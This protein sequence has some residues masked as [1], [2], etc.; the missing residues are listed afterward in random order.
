MKGISCHEE[1][2]VNGMAVTDKEIRENFELARELGCNFMR[3]AH[4]SHPDKPVIIT[5]TGGGAKAGQHGSKS[6]MFTEEHQEAL[7]KEQVRCIGKVAYIAGLSPWILYDFRT[8][9]RTNR[10]QKGYN[11]KGLL[12]EDKKYRKKAFYVLQDFYKHWKV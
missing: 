5:E 11:R 9:V 4:Y 12:S 2:V 1:S 10:F 7:Y 6:D 8:P 3:L